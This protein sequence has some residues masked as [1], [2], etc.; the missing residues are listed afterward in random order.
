MKENL[1]VIP[2]SLKQ[3]VEQSA[4]IPKNGGADFGDELQKLNPQQKKEL[5]EKVSKF[6]EYGHVLRCETALM[7]LSKNLNEIGQM[8]E[9]YAIT[10]SGDYFQ[11]E[12]VKRDFQEVKK[13]TKEFAKL[14]KECRGGLLKLNALY[15]DMGGKMQ[16]YFEI[17]TL[18]E[19]AASTGIQQQ[20]RPAPQL[21]EVSNKDGEG[22]Y[23]ENDP[24]DVE[25]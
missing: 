17:K 1:E 13:I 4:N 7:E 8:A 2:F 3:I 6:N 21:G 18:D 25:I 5:R 10:D 22:Q 16:R 9:S 14:A 20:S 23:I 11:A 15:E 24:K 19:I 12:V